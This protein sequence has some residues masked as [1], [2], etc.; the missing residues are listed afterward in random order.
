MIGDVEGPQKGD[1]SNMGID[2]TIS[3]SLKLISACHHVPLCLY[4]VGR[5]AS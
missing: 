4:Q 2:T 3:S 1:M 5:T